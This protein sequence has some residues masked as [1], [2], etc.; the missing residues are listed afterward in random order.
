MADLSHHDIGELS[1]IIRPLDSL[2][3]DSGLHLPPYTRAHNA[4]ARKAVNIPELA[5]LSS[6]ELLPIC[7]ARVP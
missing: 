7:R 1:D 2:E 3:H 4:R 5:G 6:R